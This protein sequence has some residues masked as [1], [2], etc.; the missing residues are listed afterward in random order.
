VL[1]VRPG[2]RVSVHTIVCEITK[3]D[4]QRTVSHCVTD[5]MRRR[6]L[7]V[8]KHGRS[9][10]AKKLQLPIASRGS[11]E[12]HV[13]AARPGHAFSGALARR[14]RNCAHTS[15]HPITLAGAIAPVVR[16]QKTTLSQ[17][18]PSLIATGSFHRLGG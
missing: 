10:Q 3:S 2:S 1:L 18:G 6:T 4:V 16:I 9:V 14:P 8:Q 15:A 11:A 5:L 17:C 13:C 12:V 7:V